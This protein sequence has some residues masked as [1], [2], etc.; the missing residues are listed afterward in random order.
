MQTDPAAAFGTAATDTKTRQQQAPAAKAS[1]EPSQF[2][3]DFA[4]IRE[5]GFR[6][7]VEDLQEEKLEKMRQEILAAM[8]LS[9]EALE[10]M[11][12][13]Q[14]AAI[15]KLVAQEIQARLSAEKTLDG[16]DGSGL[17]ANAL[18][19]P[20]AAGTDT[21]VAP[22]TGPGMLQVLQEAERTSLF[23]SPEDDR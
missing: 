8:G 15:E 13:E 19:N 9:D 6:A 5:K 11:P 12:A 23:G 10:E 14:R 22:G 18:Q 21:G 17:L 2:Q 16:N 20:P 7:F 1:D 4:A 3:L